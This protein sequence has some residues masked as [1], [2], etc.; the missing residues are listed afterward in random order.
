[1]P[2]NFQY[3]DF[4]VRI[5]GGSD[6]AYE[7]EVLSSL[8]SRATSR[9]KL[10]FTKSRRLKMPE[11]FARLRRGA[12]NGKPLPSPDEIGK[13]LFGSLL[14]GEV[15]TR[16]QQSLAYLESHPNEGL[17]LRLTFDLD[18]PDLI[19]VAALPWELLCERKDFLC[20]KRRTPLVRYLEVSRPPLPRLE[21]PLRILVVQSEPTDLDALNLAKEWAA[22]WQALQSQKE[23]EVGLL[24]HPSPLS[25]RDRLLDGPWHV[26][27]FM[28]HGGFNHENGEGCLYFE[29]P[30]GKAQPVTG[31][32]L[33][34]FLTEDLRLV[35][36]N[37]CQTG[38][39]PG[40]KGQ[41]P[42]RGTASALV[43]SGV[44]AVIAMQANISDPAAIAFS[45]TFYARIAAG[46]PIDAAAVEGRLAILQARPSDWATPILFTRV[47]D[48]DVLA[49]SGEPV[50]PSSTP[51]RPAQREAGPLRLGI[52]SFPDHKGRIVW[53]QEMDQEC[54]DILDL[55]SLFGGPNG[56]TILDP[57]SWQTRIVPEL[58]RFLARAASSRRPLHLNFAAHASIA[59]TAGFILNAKS[60]LDIMLRQRTQAGIVEWQAVAGP[61]AEKNLWLRR[62]DMPGDSE[63]RDVALALAVTQPVIEDV[64]L[65]LSRSGLAMSRILP[66]TLAPAPS[67]LAVRDA[68]HA[69]QLAD[70]V[71]AKIRTRTIQER[72]GVL[73][74]FAS[75]PNALLFFLG[76]L[77]HGLG[78]IQLYEHDFEGGPGAYSPSILLPPVKEPAS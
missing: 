61:S 11:E 70:G 37:A 2:K 36:L 46:D 16:F 26:L 69:M 45:S 27:H 43:E 33:G 14:V 40:G 29:S 4:E 75:A 73:H 58:Q 10:P 31:T 62:K 22:M 24:V 55:R 6:G 77:S 35:F 78:P 56:K 68:L 57:S 9:F 13:A 28:G 53:G 21:G 66:A 32:H 71:A 72:Q 76:Q 34:R 63:A 25:L 5:K 41:D 50:R 51:S 23:I 7:A 42:Y 3:K 18:D 52:R 30:E 65:Y 47:T 19:P 64:Q 54:E 15:G 38:I 8:F 60:G 44:P 17:R 39:L 48:G 59:F 12:A 49:Q 20:L 1:M 74:L 67:S